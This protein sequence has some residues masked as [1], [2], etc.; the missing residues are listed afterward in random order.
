MYSTINLSDLNSEVSEG[1]AGMDFQNVIDNMDQDIDNEAAVGRELEEKTPTS[2]QTQ[3]SQTKSKKSK[4]D[5][6]R[7]SN[8]KTESLIS[9]WSERSVLYDARHPKYFNQNERDKLLSEMAEKLNIPTR[10]I[11]AKMDNLRSYYSKQNGMIVSSKKS[12]AGS[13]QIYKPKWMWFEQ[14]AF[15]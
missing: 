13:N 9:L 15:L 2:K 6:R 14:L 1:L 12:G 4:E 10:D 11:L 3:K 8:Q 5:A 7:W